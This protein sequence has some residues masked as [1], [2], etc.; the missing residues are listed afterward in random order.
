MQGVITIPYRKTF[1][2]SRMIFHFGFVVGTFLIDSHVIMM[3]DPVFFALA[4][5][6]LISIWS[7]F[8]NLFKALSFFD[9]LTINYETRVLYHHGFLGMSG[10]YTTEKFSFSEVSD[11]MISI[12]KW[13]IIPNFS[14]FGT[15][16]SL[17]IETRGLVLS[18]KD[19]VKLIDD[20]VLSE[21]QKTL[22]RR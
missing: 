2:L 21:K 6:L 1:I 12:E 18:H 9:Y 3:P 17:R 5:P 11:A 13:S 8:T 15:K 19:I 14:F 7:F 10:S 16:E 22:A 4:L 20:I